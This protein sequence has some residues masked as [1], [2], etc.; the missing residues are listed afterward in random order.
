MQRSEA[1]LW[2]SSPKELIE[3]Y[4]RLADD[5]ELYASLGSGSIKSTTSISGWVIAKRTVPVL[6]GTMAGHP[7]IKTG[8]AGLTTE[9]VYMDEQ[10]Q[11][12]RT[13]N[14]WYRLGRPL[15]GGDAQ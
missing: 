2:F 3:T 5:L 4:R 12:A 15:I 8:K 7:S 14:R 13:V 6:L 1:D 11:L 9:V 10:Q